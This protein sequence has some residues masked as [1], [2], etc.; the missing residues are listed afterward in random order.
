DA[1][2]AYALDYTDSVAG[3]KVGQ[4]TVQITT[5]RMDDDTQERVPSIYNVKSTLAVEVKSGNN[6]F[7]FNLTSK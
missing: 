3:A 7:N 5:A 1:S 2:G 4:H 6:E